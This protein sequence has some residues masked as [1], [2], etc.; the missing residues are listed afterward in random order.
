[1]DEKQPFLELLLK[2]IFFVIL[3]FSVFTIFIQIKI[4]SMNDEVSAFNKSLAI[5]QMEMEKPTDE[6]LLKDGWVY[7]NMGEWKKAKEIMN[8]LYDKNKNLSA[9]YCLGLIDLK[10]MNT[11]DGILKLE[12]VLKRSPEHAPTL[13]NLAKVY[14]DQKYYIRTSSLLEKLVEIEPTN[15]E[16]RLLLGKTY[17]KLNKKEEA[18]KI[19]K[20]I[21]NSTNSSEAVALLRT[22]NY[23]Y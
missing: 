8:N 9:L 12:D 13:E 18:A 10:N 4:P 21:I 19:F 15:T 16:A 17:I 11:T 20:F 6:T 1:M 22:I 5:R 3:I 23:N 14:Y 7:F 2:F